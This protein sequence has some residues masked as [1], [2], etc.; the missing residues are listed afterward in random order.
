MSFVA[1]IKTVVARK[2]HN[3]CCYDIFLASNYSAEELP[4]E[5]LNDLYEMRD[6]KGKIEV[7]EE[8]FMWSGIY[9]GEFF[10]ARANKRMYEL[11]CEMEW[12]D[13]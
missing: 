7:S 13:E 3:C 2:E 12:F 11:I 4:K 6:K 5:Y 1:P 9:D 10:T 8:Y